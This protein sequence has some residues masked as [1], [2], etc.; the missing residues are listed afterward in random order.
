MEAIVL[1]G[2]VFMEL[3]HFKFSSFH[4][5]PVAITYIKILGLLEGFGNFIPVLVSWS[6]TVGS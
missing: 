5:L 4:P 6:G 1:E 3:S 2:V